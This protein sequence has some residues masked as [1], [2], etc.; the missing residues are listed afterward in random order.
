MNNGR[1]QDEAGFGCITHY[2]FFS[3]KQML[4]GVTIWD[5]KP[6]DFKIFRS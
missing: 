3:F 4:D 1:Y 5:G 2:L 6:M